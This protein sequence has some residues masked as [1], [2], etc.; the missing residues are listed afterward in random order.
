MFGQLL[1]ISD[2][3][4]SRS[5]KGYPDVQTELPVFEFVPI[6]FFFFFLLL[7]TAKEVLCTFPVGIY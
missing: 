6:D 1:N 4:Q 5:R 3:S 2:M 7:G